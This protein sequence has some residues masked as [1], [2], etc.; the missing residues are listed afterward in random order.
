MEP[1][2][3][4]PSRHGQKPNTMTGTKQAQFDYKAQTEQKKCTMRGENKQI[5]NS[6]YGHRL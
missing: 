6:C 5:Q 3:N 1:A 4:N 2:F